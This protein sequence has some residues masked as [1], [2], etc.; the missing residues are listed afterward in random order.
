MVP[1]LYNAPQVRM[2]LRFAQDDNATDT[3]IDRRR[4]FFADGPDDDRQPFIYG[5]SSGYMG[6]AV[7]NGNAARTLG[8]NLGAAITFVISDK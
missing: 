7:R 6:I 8:V 2:I 3:V 5:D 1:D 4:R